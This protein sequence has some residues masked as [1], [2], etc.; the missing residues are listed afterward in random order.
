MPGGQRALVLRACACSRGPT[1]EDETACGSRQI[2]RRARRGERPAPREWC[3][4]YRASCAASQRSWETPH[5]RRPRGV[6]DTE[7][8]R[9]AGGPRLSVERKGGELRMGARTRGAL[10]KAVGLGPRARWPELECRSRS[11]NQRDPPEG[12]D[13]TQSESSC[14]V[15]RGC[16]REEGGDVPATRG[17][18]RGV[19]HPSSP[20]WCCPTTS[21]TRRA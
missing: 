10:E 4:E 5:R 7:R 16:H 17:H 14:C 9:H 8:S 19:P 1:P 11:D 21:G 15:S 6:D 2:R 18:R 12:M 3:G 20:S 13:K